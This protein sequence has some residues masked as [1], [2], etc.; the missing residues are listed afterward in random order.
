GYYSNLQLQDHGGGVFDYNIN[1]RIF[2]RNWGHG[3]AVTDHG[4]RGQRK[5]LQ[6]FDRDGTSVH[7]IYRTDNGDA[8]AWERL[9]EQFRAADQTPSMAPKA[10]NRPYMPQPPAN[11]DATALCEQWRAMTDIHQF[12]PMLRD[13]KLRRVDALRL[14]D[15]DLARPVAAD[16]W[17]GIV[18]QASKSGLPIMVFTRSPGVAQIH[19][20]PVHKL[21]ESNGWFNVLDP[22]FNLHMRADAV[23]EAW[24]VY[25]P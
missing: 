6:F 10:I 18:Q 1:L 2:F 17:R 21:V 8:A 5:S 16:A 9:V 20:G 3:F 13:H 25:K 23:S 11:A 15:E 14:A 12:W 7:K 4:P 19:T 22:T 24:V